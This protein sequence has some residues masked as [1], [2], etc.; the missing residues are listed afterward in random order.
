M[1]NTTFKDVKAS[2][3]FLNEML[4]KASRNLIGHAKRF[5]KKMVGHKLG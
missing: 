1:T 4:K 3:V 2:M 5:Q